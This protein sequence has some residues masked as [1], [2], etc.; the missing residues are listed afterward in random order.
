MRKYAQASSVTIAIQVDDGNLILA[1]EDNGQ[2]FDTQEAATSP[3]MGLRNLEER[4][5]S[6]GGTLEVVSSPGQGTRVTASL[7]IR[8]A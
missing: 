7:P 4:V 5:R 2:G 8:Q 1:V 3:G 6:A